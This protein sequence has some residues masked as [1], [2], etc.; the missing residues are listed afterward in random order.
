MSYL[1][2]GS[3]RQS[4]IPLFAMIRQTMTNIVDHDRVSYCNRC[5]VT[6]SVH[7]VLLTLSSRPLNPI[8][9]ILVLSP[10][11]QSNSLLR[12]GD[13]H[14]MLCLYKARRSHNHPSCLRTSML[15]ILHAAQLWC[16]IRPPSLETRHRCRVWG[17]YS[18]ILSIL[19]TTCFLVE[20]SETRI[21]HA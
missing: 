2:P 18:V 21:L 19:D 15:S 20:Q 8:H 4:L 3:C 9:I 17:M 5:G 12:P 16:Y 1:F 7:I 11:Y 6:S 14:R 10:Q 13:L